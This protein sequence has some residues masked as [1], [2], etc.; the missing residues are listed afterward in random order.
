MDFLFSTVALWVGG[1]K[2]TSRV[3]GWP[4]CE[5]RAFYR[6]GLVASDCCW[7]YGILI[8]AWITERYRVNLF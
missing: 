3:N 8:A 7:T 2:L 4:G 6:V 5:K 1:V